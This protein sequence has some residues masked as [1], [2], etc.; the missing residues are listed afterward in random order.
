MLLTLQMSWFQIH[1]LQ[2]TNPSVYVPL[3]S[4]LTTIT[5]LLKCKNLF[6]DT[7]GIG[8]DDMFIML[9]TWRKTSVRLPVEERLGQTYSEAAVSITITSVT[10]AL[11]FGIGSITKLPAIR[12]F[13]LYTGIAIIFDYLYQVR[14]VCVSWVDEV[15]CVA[16][17]VGQGWV[18]FTRKQ[19]T[20]R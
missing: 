16:G 18:V 4:D 10:D 9:A 8:I 19:R 5:Y 14:F 2:W 20:G 1:R 6:L 3:W 7:S 17:W 15:V 12:V 11:A 13:C